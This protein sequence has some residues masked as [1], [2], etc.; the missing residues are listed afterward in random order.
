MHSSQDNLKKTR[1]KTKKTWNS[2]GIG[3]WIFKLNN[4]KE[5]IELK[6]LGR[7]SQVVFSGAMVS[8]LSIFHGVLFPA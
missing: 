3:G 7:N 5:L 2:F 1:G 8:T 6:E 4:S